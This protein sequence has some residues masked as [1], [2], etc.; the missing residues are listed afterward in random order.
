MRL[1]YDVPFES[2]LYFT[3]AMGRIGRADSEGRIEILG[4][5]LPTPPDGLRLRVCPKD[6]LEATTILVSPGQAGI[7]TDGAVIDVQKLIP[8]QEPA[9]WLE[10]LPEPEDAAFTQ[11]EPWGWLMFVALAGSD[12]VIAVRR[13]GSSLVLLRGVSE[14]SAV[15]M[16]EGAL[17]VL[18]HGRGE[19][20]RI[21][22]GTV[23]P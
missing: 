19:L 18:G 5:G 20:V 13:D 9:P 11:D 4:E 21:R 2:P 22:P 10:G 17:W 8:F 6:F 1:D 3:D 7:G 23:A 14:P 15:L 12:E 16:S